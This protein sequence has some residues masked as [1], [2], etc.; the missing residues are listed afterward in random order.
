MNSTGY[1]RPISD[2]LATLTE[3]FRHQSRS[4]VRELLENAHGRFDEINYDN[5]NGGTTTWALRLEVAV[6]LFAAL[7]PR[8][9]IVEEE[10]LSKLSY[11]N[12]RH[13]NDPVGEVTLTPID[14]GASA[15]GQRIAPS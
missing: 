13:P 3:I 11:L 6:P 4:E 10:I 5:W 8:L 9:K 12:R 1:P 7:E 15:L 2:V 14:P